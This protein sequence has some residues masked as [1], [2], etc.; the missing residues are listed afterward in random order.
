MIKNL[1]LAFGLL[2]CSFA[3][4][5]QPGGNGVVPG[6]GWFDSYSADGKCYI[7]STFDHGVGETIVPTPVGGQTVRQVAARIGAGPGRA[8]NPIYND[9]QCGNGPANNAGDEDYDQCPG[10]VDLGAAGCSIIGPEWDLVT[11][12]SDV[13]IGN[14]D[15]PSSSAGSCSANG[16]T[17]AAAT[18]AFASQCAGLQRADCDPAL[19]D[20][21]RVWM[22]ATY[23]IDS[24]APISTPTAV[25]QTATSVVAE[26]VSAQ[27]SGRCDALGRDLATA[28]IAYASACS[29]ERLD[30]DPTGIG[31][32]YLCASYNIATTANA[33]TTAVATVAATAPPAAA[34]AVSIASISTVSAVS[35]NTAAANTASSSAA[36]VPVS[37]LSALRVALESGNSALLMQDIDVAASDA[38]GAGVINVSGLSNVGIYGQGYS[39]T[40]STG[41]SSASLIYG[42]NTNNFFLDNVVLQEVPGPD[43][44]AL[45]TYKHM[46]WFINS[47]EITLQDVEVAHSYGYAIYANGVNGFTFDNS[48]LRDSGVLGLYIGHGDNPSTNVTI[49]NNDFLRNT[50]NGLAIWG[51][52]GVVVD[53]NIFDNNHIIGVFPTAARFGD[54]Y[55]GGGQVYLAQG[56][57]IDFTNNTIQ[58]GVC[59]NC[60][61]HNGPLR[62]GVTGLEFGLPNRGLTVT[63][64]L[65][66]GNTIRDNDAWGMHINSGASLDASTV[67]L[68]NIVENNGGGVSVGTSHSNVV[69]PTNIT[70]ASVTSPT[71]TTAAAPVLEPDPES[72]D[73]ASVLTN[74]CEA[75]ASNLSLA[76]AAYAAQCSLPRKDCDPVAAGYTCASY[77]LGS[78]SPSDRFG[79]NTPEP[80]V[81]N[82]VSTSISSS[83]AG[84]VRIEAESNFGEGWVNRGSYIEFTGSNSFAEPTYGV[85][86]YNVEIPAAGDWEM[87]W[88]AT[89]AQQTAGRSDLHNDAWA[90][91]NGSPIS[92]FHDVR[93]FRKVF[94]SGNGDW[95]TAANVE[96]GSH[97]F[98]KFRQRLSQG[99]YQ[100]D[101]SGRS[102]GYAIDYIEFVQ[103]NSQGGEQTVTQTPVVVTGPLPAL[104][105]VNDYLD[106][107]NQPYVDGDLLSLH[108]DS[109]LDPDDMQAMILSR[110]I[111]ND[112]SPTVDFI[113][114][115]GTKRQINDRIL[116][117]ST[118]H[119]RSLF[120]GGFEAWRNGLSGAE[121]SQLYASTVNTF[122]TAWALTLAS[123]HRVHV[124]EGGPSDFTASVIDELRNRGVSAANLKN[125]R[126]IQHS[127]G[128]NEDN[129][130]ET[131]LTTVRRYADYIRIAN[132][133]AGNGE[134]PGHTATPDYEFKT[135]SHAQCAPFRARALASEYGAQW[136][137]AF[138]AINNKCDGSDAV[139]VMWILGIP[140]NLAPTLATFANRYF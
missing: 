59:T 50:T 23:N 91:M 63:N 55:T 38:V 121:Q 44:P 45:G 105:G 118:A 42:A 13:Q 70:V 140:T 84:T 64:T 131:A 20:N 106:T 35:A 86:S 21:V 96:L 24:G 67:I 133:N 30:C 49:S 97:N 104:G 58:N 94:T 127:W 79:A 69:S 19:L 54:T 2:L 15:V 130:S 82:N 10:R 29:A 27:Q 126:V 43:V 93:A 132:G 101:I 37:T 83:T 80:T 109:S 17:L 77:T 137:T 46:L 56:T 78:A 1:P 48:L 75:T 12:Y 53:N 65:V 14:T 120:P 60:Y 128:W 41:Q 100:F 89:A 57:N 62:T 122:A 134:G 36:G 112:H 40:R 61:V 32:Q 28:K 90:K 117:G 26:S 81:A 25:A 135:S 74:T 116:T 119:M 110:E 115:N 22:C 52:D 71:T 98:S 3:V 139:E 9:V 34:N 99:T 47:S 129:T 111:L 123:G 11:A 18:Q 33:P 16:N 138:N 7:D 73:N 72:V 88:R 5:A 68:D 51:A 76:I 107:F 113:A 136:Q 87:R 39:I 125:I 66:E 95:H 108:W 6:E 4:N 31:D 114:V 85:L 102:T 124:A 92:G 103:I 8:G